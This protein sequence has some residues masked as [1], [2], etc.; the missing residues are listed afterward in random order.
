MTKRKQKKAQSTATNKETN[1]PSDDGS[2]RLLERL[3]IL[4]DSGYALCGSFLLLMVAVAFSWYADGAGSGTASTGTSEIP[5]LHK[6]KQVNERDFEEMYEQLGPVP[7]MRPPVVFSIDDDLDEIHAAYKQEG[8]VA[9]RGLVSADL[10][11]RLDE[12]SRELITKDPGSKKNQRNK[13]FHTM[14]QNPIF[15][16]DWTAN[17][18]NTNASATDATISISQHSNPF[19]QVALLSQVPKLASQLMLPELEANESV[20]VIRDIFLSK[21]KEEFICG[22]H[23]DDFGFW[24]ATASSPGINAWIALDDMP[25]VGGGGF[26]LAVG[27]HATSWRDEAQYVTGATTF[28]PEEGFQSAADMFANRT[29]SGTCNI[30]TAAPHLY[31]RM[32]ETK[33]IWDLKRG[34]IIFHQRWLFHRT[35][36]FERDYVTGENENLVYRRYS[37][38]YAPGSAIIPPGFGTELSVLWDPSN[39]NRTADAVSKLDGPWYPQVWPSANDG[40]LEGLQDLIDKKVPIAQERKLA[41]Q[42]EMQ[43]FLKQ[44]ARETQSRQR[45]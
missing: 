1:T 33:R 7:E 8:V 37:V 31:R 27:S 6:N 40:E 13:Q 10:L 15:L 39:A 21:D 34:D 3:A 22:W 25:A 45:K 9:V 19:V 14:Q 4:G 29:G 30:Q 20:R 12:A 16:N 44:A 41:R 18:T 26:A 43:P 38:R 2:F 36:A 23:V 35:V 11:E 17:T 28:Y 5:A 24:P 32:E 42:K